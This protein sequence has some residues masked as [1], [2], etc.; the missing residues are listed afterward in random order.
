MRNGVEDDGVRQ[1]LDRK[2]LAEALVPAECLVD[3]AG[4]LADVRM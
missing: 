1:S 2:I 3:A 4:V